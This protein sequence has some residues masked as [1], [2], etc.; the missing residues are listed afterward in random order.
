M[1]KSTTEKIKIVDNK[2]AELNKPLSTY[3]LSKSLKENMDMMKTL[4]QDDDI[5]VVR[6]L[7]NSDSTMHFALTYCNGLVNARIINENII[8]PLLESIK[9][10]SNDVV[11]YLLRHIIHIDDIKRTEQI[12]EIVTNVTYGDVILFVD[13]ASE[14][15]ILNAKQFDKRQ[16]IEPDNEKILAGPREGFT[17]SLMT[18]LSLIQR[19]LRTNELKF[20]YLTIGDKTNTQVCLCYIDSVV[21]KKV[22]EELSKRLSK[23]KI[24]GVLDTNYITELT[25]D[26]KWSPFRTTGYT[27]RPDVIVGKILEGRVALLLDGTPIALTVPYLF[28]ENFES[29]EDYYFSFYYTSFSRMI[30]ILGFFMTIIVPAFYIAVVVY[31]KEMLPTQLFINVAIERQTAPLPAALEAFVMLIVFDII[32]ETGVRMPNNI[33]QALSIVGAIVIGQAAVE[34]K[35]VAAPMIIVVAFTGITSL[36]VPKLNAPV[37]LIRFCLLILASTLGLFGLMVGLS[38]VLINVLNLK[39]FG[40]PETNPTSTYKFQNIKD[41]FF[42]APWWKMTKRPKPLTANE[43]RL[44]TEGENTTL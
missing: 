35:L 14:V 28:I 37:I 2:V 27:E 23:I 3:Q 36:L 29:G 1:A 25:K 21:N 41:L 31:H 6:E 26:N 7:D 10:E 18:N 40:I 19:K 9:V 20:K 34:A 39:S 4:F 24:D 8:K 22:L 12:K 42:R 38:L 11:E 43:T 17:E 44:K 30:R 32:K 33:G 15:L 16:I 5:F 13:G